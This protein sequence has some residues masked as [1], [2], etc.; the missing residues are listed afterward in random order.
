MTVL[1]I[2][3][4]AILAGIVAYQATKKKPAQDNLQDSLAPEKIEIAPVQEPVAEQPAPVAQEA[5]AVEA[6]KKVAAK[7][8]QEPKPAVKKVVTKKAK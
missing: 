8:T 4:V 1:I 7:K 3:S 6:P 5:P 2:V